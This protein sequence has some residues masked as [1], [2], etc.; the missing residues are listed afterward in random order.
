MS[1]LAIGMLGLMTAATFVIYRAAFHLGVAM[2]YP[3]WI[4]TGLLV[5]LSVLPAFVEPIS[6]FLAPTWGFRAIRDATL[7]GPA[8]AG[9]AVF[10]SPRGRFFA[11]AT[12]C[13]GRFQPVPRARPTLRLT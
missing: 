12:G 8:W 2:Q 9:M 6:W 13:L 4:V 10:A 5:P 3:V 11:I 1:A 7:G